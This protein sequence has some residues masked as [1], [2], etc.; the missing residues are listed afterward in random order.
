VREIN[1]RHLL[2]ALHLVF[3]SIWLGCI[4]TEALFERA[5]L[6]EDRSTH[7]VLA[8]LHARVDNL[9]ELPAILVVFA[10]GLALFSQSW[11]RTPSFYVMAFAG[12][13]AIGLNVFCVWL[14]YRRRSAASAGAWSQF[15]RFDH[16]QHRAGAG[17]LLLVVAALVAG[18]WGKGAA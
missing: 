1:M 4:L 13:A 15:A 14:V 17:V 16:I 11:P 10:T 7:L 12:A 2:L 18:V 3:A 6:A 9:I 8:R 5:L